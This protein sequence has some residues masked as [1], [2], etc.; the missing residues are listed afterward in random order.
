MILTSLLLKKTTCGSFVLLIPVMKLKF[1][2]SS[3]VQFPAVRDEKEEIYHQS[4][5]VS[6]NTTFAELTL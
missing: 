5:I 4:Y 3:S 2:L 6:L 1:L